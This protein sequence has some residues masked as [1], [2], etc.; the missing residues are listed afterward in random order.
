MDQEVDFVLPGYPAPSPPEQSPHDIFNPKD[1][2][3][4][5]NRAR[6][7]SEDLVNDF[8]TLV[9]YLLQG[10][11][12][13][14]AKVRSVF[15][16]LS[17]QPVL[18]T[19][20]SK[21]VKPDT[22]RAWLKRVKYDRFCYADLFAI[23]CR[24]AGVPCA[25]IRGSS[26]GGGFEVG[27][28][29]EL[30]VT[31]RW[32]AVHV[33]GSWQLVNVTW[34]LT[35]T[36]GVADGTWLMV[37]KDGVACREREESKKTVWQELDE[38][39][40]LTKP[41]DFNV[42]C[43]AKVPDWQ[44]LSDP[45][46]DQEFVDTPRFAE[47]YF[48]SDWE[49]VTANTGVLVAK[50]GTCKIAFMHPT[51]DV[52][53]ASLTYNLYFNAAESPK[54]LSEELQIDR[55]VVTDSRLGEKSLVTRLPQVGVY[56]LEVAGI[57]NDTL[58]PL[59]EFRVE[60]RSIKTTP[61]PFPDMCNEI[62]YTETAA[63]QGLEQPTHEEGIVEAK[64]GDKLQFGFK[65]NK[66]QPRKFHAIVT[67]NTMPQDQ[68]NSCTEVHQTQQALTVSVKVPKNEANSEIGV[69]IG[70]Q[71]ESRDGDNQSGEISYDSVINY[72]VTQDKKLVCPEEKAI[73][74]K[75]T[76]LLDSIKNCD[77]SRFFTVYTNMRD[78][79][80]PMTRSKVMNFM[81]EMNKIRIA[82]MRDLMQAMNATDINSLD[83]ALQDYEKYMMFGEDTQDTVRQAKA[84]LQL[85]I[86]LKSEDNRDR[87]EKALRG[88]YQVKLTVNTNVQRAEDTL[89]SVYEK[90]LGEAFVKRSLEAVTAVL[91]TVE[92]SCVS[93]RV[94][95]L[96]M[97]TKAKELL[98][99]LKEMKQLTDKVG[100]MKTKDLN[101]IAGPRGKE[102]HP[103]VQSVLMATF[104]LLGEK[105]ADL[106]NWETVQNLLER[107]SESGVARAM[108]ALDVDALRESQVSLA[109][110]HVRSC[111][112]D[113]L[114]SEDPNTAVFL[115]W[116]QG[117]V[118]EKRGRD[119][120]KQHNSQMKNNSNN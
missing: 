37:E 99:H 41:E 85:L 39:W 43:H 28:K 83:K 114:L 106:W 120:V 52:H 100:S 12:S 117:I 76:D 92:T 18:T 72:I 87:L 29:G 3:D 112:L 74:K 13:D 40:F 105:E 108:A 109:E 15:V 44:L 60:C 33:Q 47:E 24:K 34:A 9:S 81:K 77:I 88:A 115:K 55:Y 102:P 58:T 103:T 8:D 78:Q 53:Y 64:P 50:E 96:Y 27:Q 113:V 31:N 54:P 22:P 32:N 5:D 93:N 97:C 67:H 73:I 57:L 1:Y 14:L 101:K 86:A 111:H 25:I 6:Q 79:L 65:F 61:Q 35:S 104:I 19:Q 45:W 17:A 16:W 80:D 69:S 48:R 51:E 46:T 30:K 71:E 94:K 62:G 82:K 89:V 42:F 90:D 107:R 21:V 119:G 118:R 66:P 23:M 11:E 49:L 95:G 59:G 75:K 91:A 2:C 116:V 68:L 10:A 36:D 84:A 4:I 98:E 110:G 56:R 26:K 7:A 20:F 38:F 70:V 63:I